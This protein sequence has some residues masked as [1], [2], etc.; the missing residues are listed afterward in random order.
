MKRGEPTELT[1]A[2]IDILSML[3]WHRRDTDEWVSIELLIKEGWRYGLNPE[4]TYRG[5]LGLAGD[6]LIDVS[7]NKICLSVA[8]V[9]H[10]HFLH[11]HGRLAPPPRGGAARD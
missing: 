4:M 8:G 11:R 6:H 7:S 5:L 3:L 2:K 9:A 10:T 1:S